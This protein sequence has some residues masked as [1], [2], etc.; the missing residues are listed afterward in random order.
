MYPPSFAVEPQEWQRMSVITD[1]M[2]FAPHTPARWYRLKKNA[3]Y[4]RV[5][6]SAKEAARK[7]AE[8]TQTRDFENA[9]RE[10]VRIA[11]QNS[12]KKVLGAR[13]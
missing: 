9:L 13:E 7:K 10:H 5:A 11:R 1:S 3:F 8:Q 6:R 12:G 2:A 4:G